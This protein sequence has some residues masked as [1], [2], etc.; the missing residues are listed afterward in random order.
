MKDFNLV[1]IVTFFGAGEWGEWM[2]LRIKRML[3]AIFTQLV[4][5]GNFALSG[6]S[7]ID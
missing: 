6:Q 1:E 3:D 4:P 2:I 7:R 5:D